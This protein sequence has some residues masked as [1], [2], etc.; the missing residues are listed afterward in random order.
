MLDVVRVL[1]RESYTTN[2]FVIGGIVVTLSPHKGHP[3]GF[4]VDF[5]AFASLVLIV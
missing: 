3:A 1:L 4:F 2:R 5:A